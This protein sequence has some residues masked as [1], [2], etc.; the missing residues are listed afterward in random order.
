MTIQDILEEL[1]KTDQQL[2]AAG[3]DDAAKHKLKGLI[4]DLKTEL[5][6]HSFDA[7]RDISTMTVVDVSQLPQMRQ[8][9]QQVINDEQRRVELVKRITGLA[10][11]ALTAAGIPVPI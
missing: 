2:A 3:I 4:I 10:S 6:M 7:L 9:L 11:R 1:K 8:Q 5:V